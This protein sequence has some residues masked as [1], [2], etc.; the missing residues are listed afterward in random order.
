MPITDPK[1]HA[2]L[3]RGFLATHCDDADLLAMLQY[4]DEPFALY[5][6]SRAR[7]STTKI[8]LTPC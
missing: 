6:S 4:H 1:S 3:A 2:S 5:V 7:A 8:G